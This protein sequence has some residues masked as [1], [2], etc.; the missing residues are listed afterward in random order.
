MNPLPI[1]GKW[2]SWILL[3]PILITLLAMAPWLGERMPGCLF[4]EKTGFLCP[5]C[6]AT[7]SAISLNEGDW[8]GAMKNNF[9]FVSGFIFGVIWIV[10]LAVAKKFP[11][12]EGLR[13]FHFRLLFLWGIL[14]ALVVFSLLRNISALDFLRPVF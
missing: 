10:V 12:V 4:Y 7:R 5:G 11:Q 1:R 6:G 13:F 14:T 3:A 8:L 2:P 9:L